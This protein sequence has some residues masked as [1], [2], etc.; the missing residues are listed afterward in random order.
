MANAKQQKLTYSTFLTT[1][2]IHEPFEFDCGT[3]LEYLK[4]DIDNYVHLSWEDMKKKGWKHR[5]IMASN[6][7]VLT[8]DVASLAKKLAETQSVR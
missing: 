2:H 7:T 8:N 1:N 4:M 5:E 6:V 3:S